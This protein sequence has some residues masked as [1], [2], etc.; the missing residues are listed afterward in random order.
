MTKIEKIINDTD[1]ALRRLERSKSK[2]LAGYMNESYRRIATEVNRI[3]STAL[4]ESNGQSLAFREARAR[5]LLRQLEP[6]LRQLEAQKIMPVLDLNSVLNEAALLGGES[7]NSL[8]SVFADELEFNAVVN[9]SRVEAAVTNSAARLGNHSATAIQKIEREVVD[10]LIQGKG[11]QRVNK[12]IRQALIGDGRTPQG[13]LYHRAETIAITEIGNAQ[14]I[15]RDEF[16]QDQG[17][18]LVERFVTQDDR[19]CR[20]CVPRHG[21]ITKRENTLEKLHPRCRCYLAPVRRQWIQ[22]GL[23]DPKA[24]RNERKALLDELR[25]RGIQPST[26]SSPFEKSQGIKRPK[27]IYR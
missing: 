23:V 25:A 19:A 7:A 3:Y 1:T 17:V 11:V 21:E 2:A 4:T 8:L 27:A 9:V 5:A 6:A 16:Y 10:A 18:S 13:G 14:A 22:L 15:A 26:G 20:V 24:S 12:G